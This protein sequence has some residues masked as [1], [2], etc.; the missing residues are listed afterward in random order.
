[1]NEDWLSCGIEEVGGKQRVCD[2]INKII[3][4]SSTL[5]A[6][7]LIDAIIDLHLLLSQR[8]KNKLD[9]PINWVIHQELITV[10]KQDKFD[11]YEMIHKC[12][13]ERLTWQVLRRHFD[14]TMANLDKLNEDSSQNKQEL[15]QLCT[16]SAYK[17]IYDQPIPLLE[18]MDVKKAEDNLLKLI[19]S[20]IGDMSTKPV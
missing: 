7:D 13:I 4:A 1:M 9:V 3:N 17:L 20:E 6:K 5:E 12:L 14:E 15:E 18:T 10:M 2:A 16:I 19:S 8:N 11:D